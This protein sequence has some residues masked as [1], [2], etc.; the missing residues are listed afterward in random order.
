MRNP[1]LFAGVPEAPGNAY[2]QPGLPQR[3][4]RRGARRETLVRK[5]T[6]KLRTRAPLRAHLCSAPINNG[7]AKVGS[8]LLGRSS[9]SISDPPPNT[10]RSVPL[11]G[12]RISWPSLCSRPDS[13]YGVKFPEARTP[14]K[15]S[16]WK[17]EDPGRET[18]WEV[19][20]AAVFRAGPPPLR[21]SG[22]ASRRAAPQTAAWPGNSWSSA[23]AGCG[24]TPRSAVRAP[25]PSRETSDSCGGATAAILHPIPIPKGAKAATAP[26][27]KSLA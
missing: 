19:E 11:G 3:C 12:S 26:D 6:E 20:K 17:I 22:R 23:Y 24:S 25:R 8:S 7:L 14:Q 18:P 9:V 21:G 1:P 4:A 15:L 13:T 5:A 2:V 27:P 16:P 10:A